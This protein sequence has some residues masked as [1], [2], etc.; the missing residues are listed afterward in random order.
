MSKKITVA[1]LISSASHQKNKWSWD[2]YI[3][4]LHW[5]FKNTDS[6]SFDQ[7]LLFLAHLLENNV[8]FRA[9]F[10]QKWSQFFETVKFDSLWIYTFAGESDSFFQE[11]I[12]ALNQKVFSSPS[13]G[14]E[15]SYLVD[16][17]IQNNL[18]SS[19]NT[20]TFTY[21]DKILSHFPSAPIETMRTEMQKSLI[22][23]I[24]IL[25]GKNI[26]DLF[27]PL[28]KIDS[29]YKFDSNFIKTLDLVT[30]TEL[31]DLSLL[32]KLTADNLLA[33]NGVIDHFKDT[34]VSLNLLYKMKKIRARLA[35]LQ[36]LY[37]LYENFNFSS[38]IKILAERAAFYSL[39]FQ[40]FHY[41]SQL[42]EVVSQTSAETGDHYVART[43]NDMRYLFYSACGGGFI[44]GFT[45]LIK[46]L[47]SYAPLAPFVTGL[48][49]SI[50]YAISFVVIYL[51]GFSLATKQPAAIANHLA[52]KWRNA[53]KA[54]ILDEIGHIFKSQFRAVLGNVGVVI[55]VVLGIS[56][57]SDYFFNKSFMSADK[58]FQQIESL[59]ILSLTP[60]YA[61]M[62]GFV[63]WLSTFVT[64][65]ADNFFKVHEFD[66]VMLNSP[67]V[68]S[69]LESSSKRRTILFIKNN[70]GAL[71]GNIFLGFVLGLTPVIGDF[72]G[73]PLD[74]RHVTLSSGAIAASIYTLGIDLFY[75]YPIYLAILGV[76]ITG[77]LN[78]SVSFY[79]S[80]R[81]AQNEDYLSSR[82]EGKDGGKL[83]RLYLLRKLMFWK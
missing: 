14:T 32:R 79:I 54:E 8:E 42:I 66:Q 70:F 25:S 80:L 82:S 75:D 50:N 34:G 57:L 27:T 60:L 59:S 7:K 40:F 15:V 13:S 9:V 12:W 51:L 83:L 67:K 71:C 74:V 49:F 46:T 26:S 58:A 45:V 76:I 11:F 18:F 24:Y 29:H 68:F 6:N 72:L 21:F 1:D 77:L 37:D 22:R 64:G 4:F 47:I 5:F 28:F 63:L 55:P 44:T 2:W 33:T 10:V 65:V 30:L 69:F 61:F 41:S 81:V 73:L 56:Y 16:Y 52:S 78:L 62:T 3:L 35:R 38:L 19:D 17:A 39:R 48:F 53:S 43:A 23:A 31:K 36:N 20:I